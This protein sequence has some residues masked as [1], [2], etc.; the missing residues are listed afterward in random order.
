MGSIFFGSPRS[1]ADLS[2]SYV[3][4]EQT[5]GWR[6]VDFKMFG[7]MFKY[8]FPVVTHCRLACICNMSRILYADKVHSLQTLLDSGG[9][10]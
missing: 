10:I 6:D 8:I 2:L 3:R 1:S 4:R 5:L 7:F 9:V